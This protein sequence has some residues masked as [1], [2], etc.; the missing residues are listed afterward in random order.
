FKVLGATRA[1]LLRSYMLEFAMLG[2]VAALI[3]SLLG[4][5]AGYVL[6]ER[7]MDIA[8]TAPV[9]TVAATALAAVAVT[10]LFG[11]LGTWRL[12]GQPAAPA[13]REP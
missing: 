7:V 4:L 5:A 10:A 8:W 1:D 2:G 12:L 13:L 3:G 6:L 11:F 9:A